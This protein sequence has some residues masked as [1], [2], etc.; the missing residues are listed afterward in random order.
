MPIAQRSQVASVIWFSA[1]PIVMAHYGTFSMR[2]QVGEAPIHDTK[3]TTLK[4]WA[5]KNTKN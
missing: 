2:G 3:Y 4:R 1:L 5:P